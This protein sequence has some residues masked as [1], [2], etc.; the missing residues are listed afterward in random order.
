MFLKDHEADWQYDAED[1]AALASVI[2]DA[3]TDRA[4]EIDKALGMPWNSIRRN[5]TV[6]IKMPPNVV[7]KLYAATFKDVARCY[8]CNNFLDYCLDGALQDKC[9]ACSHKSA[10]LPQQPVGPTG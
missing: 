7:A 1:V 8:E 2:R 6:K 3:V 9:Y 4:K 10:E 5:A